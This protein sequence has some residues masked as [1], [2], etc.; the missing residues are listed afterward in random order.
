MAAIPKLIGRAWKS[1]VVT[2]AAFAVLSVCQ[3]PAHG[4]GDKGHRIVA[5]IADAHLAEQSQEEI[6]K[7]LPPE[8]T[9]ADAAVWPDEEGRRITD[10]DRL[11]YI[12]IPD[13]ANGYDQERDCKARNCMVEALNWFISVV[14]DTKVPINVRRLALRFVVHLVG[15]MHQPLHAGRREDRNG[16]DIAVS[17]RGQTN[18]LHQFWDINLIEMVE[19]STYKVATMLGGSLSTEE[20]ASWQSG[21]PNTWTDESFKLSRSYA[22]NLG[23]STELSDDY[24][25]VALSIV[26]R[27]LVQ[28]G[29]RL[30]WLLDNAFK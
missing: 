24:V 25:A 12:S 15:D 30:S 8:T 18:N 5:I 16:T 20:R 28:A 29:V 27:R 21:N 26:R 19:G 7:L 17:Y 22:Y 2:I 13:D 14:G 11:H 1:F 3:Q 4:W 9:L 6:R 10:F 23:E